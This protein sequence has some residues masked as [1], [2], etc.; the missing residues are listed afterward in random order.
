MEA[1]EEPPNRTKRS[2]SNRLMSE[3]LVPAPVDDDF[4]RMRVLP[5]SDDEESVAWVAT[6]SS[7]S[8][9]TSRSK[10]RRIAVTT[11]DVSEELALLIRTSSPS[12]VSAGFTMH[13]SQIMR[14]ATTSSNLKGTYTKALRDAA[15]FITA[16]WKH[17]SSVR[18]RSTSDSDT[19]MARL[20]A[21]EDEN[22]ALRRE[23]SKLAA[24]AGECPR[25]SGHAWETGRED[26]ID[27]ARFVAL[28]RMVKEMKP[29][30]IRAIEE[31]LGGE[32]QRRRRTPDARRSTE[33]SAIPQPTQPTS[34]QR[35][36]DGGEWRV[37]EKRRKK[38][39]K[40]KKTV[41]PPQWTFE[42]HFELLV[43]RVTAAANALCGLLPNI[44]GAGV[45]VRRLYEGVIRSRVLY[46]APVWAEDLAASRRSLIALRRL[47]RTTGIRIARGYRTTSY[48]SAT[49]L[50]ASPPFE[51]Q[52]LALRWVYGTP[53][54][55]ELG[56]AAIP[57]HPGGGP[58]GDLGAMALSTAGRGRRAAA[59]S[60]S[61]RASQLGRLERA[62]RGTAD[63]PDDAIAHRARSVRR[64]PAED[65]QRGDVTC[66]HCEDEEARRNIRWSFARRGRNSDASCSSRS[67][68]GWPRKRWWRPC[69]EGVGSSPPFALSVSR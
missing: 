34:L 32:Q 66:H 52:A 41:A 58:A 36:Q 22:A 62:R 24:R 15:S 26:T 45:G 40:L 67:A 38:R 29:S 1:A 14:V 64:V 13:V 9:T 2:S 10:K 31:R 43:P 53:E 61:R 27:R 6:M 4:A 33:G 47:H 54:G 35:E 49:V 68:R 63:I 16:A 65:S 23:V 59:P 57:E 12:D 48:A 20:T 21:L 44:G 39:G 7:R 25:C 46:G 19:A 18:T 42:P 60:R 51:L 11:P 5:R 28:E 3:F 37:V 8:S 17:E 55:F 30:I 50:A 69:S 56:R